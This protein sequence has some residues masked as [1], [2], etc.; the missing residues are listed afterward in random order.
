MGYLYPSNLRDAIA[1]GILEIWN[2]YALRK[3]MGERS[4]QIAESLTW[5]Q[6]ANDYL[7]LYE[8]TLQAVHLGRKLQPYMG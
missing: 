8:R 5:E 1:K 3:Q 2:D 6:V 4:R 7:N